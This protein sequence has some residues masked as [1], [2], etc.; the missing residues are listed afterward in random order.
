M[1]IPKRS[2]SQWKAQLWIALC[3]LVVC[4][5]KP[6]T[7]KETGIEKVL[8]QWRED[9]APKPVKFMGQNWNRNLYDP[10]DGCSRSV[11]G[12]LTDTFSRK[13]IRVLKRLERT[14][15]RRAAALS[16][17]F[18]KDSIV[19][20]QCTNDGSGTPSYSHRNEVT[21]VS[22]TLYLMT[23]VLN[24]IKVALIPPLR[25]EEA[26]DR[27]P[28]KN[29]KAP[30]KV[31]QTLAEVE[32]ALKAF[33]ASHKVPEVAV[34]APAVAKTEWKITDLPPTKSFSDTK[35]LNDSTLAQKFEEAF[36]QKK[37]E[38][39][40]NENGKA[41]LAQLREL[42][43]ILE[44]QLKPKEAAPEAAEFSTPTAL[45]DFVVTSL[46]ETESFRA[47]PTRQKPK[48]WK[49]FPKDMT[50][51]TRRLAKASVVANAPD[52]LKKAAESVPSKKSNK[53]PVKRSKKR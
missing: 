36:P 15:K 14:L 22:D 37:D 50:K 25:V 42:G 1:R 53:K 26:K 27:K 4:I 49:P 20:E 43:E 8:K 40:L 12:K 6:F 13:Q 32:D 10:Y 29:E 48:G 17:L 19:A 9:L 34:Q 44:N 2:W 11:R 47:R 18:P 38:P 7:L 33:D 24:E 16:K 3:A 39:K 21:H 52:W 51:T 23:K 46:T 35:G 41:M 30:T 5:R 28:L 31:A 45:K